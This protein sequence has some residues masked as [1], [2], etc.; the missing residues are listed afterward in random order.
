MWFWGRGGWP[1]AASAAVGGAHRREGPSRR[2]SCSSSSDPRLRSP[3]A[4]G[5]CCWPTLI[6]ILPAV[7]LPAAAPIPLP[8]GCGVFECCAT[9]VSGSVRGGA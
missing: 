7:I 8:S 3:I 1:R 9:K 6:S 5:R 2:S 4:D